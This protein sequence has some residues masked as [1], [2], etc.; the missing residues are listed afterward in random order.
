MAAN[1][2][3]VSFILHTSTVVDVGVPVFFSNEEIESPLNTEEEIYP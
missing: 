3:F 2:I 1:V